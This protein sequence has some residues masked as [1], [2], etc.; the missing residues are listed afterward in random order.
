MDALSP[1]ASTPE[2]GGDSPSS[3]KWG[4]KGLRSPLRKNTVSRKQQQAA[5]AASSPPA[6]A[7]SP[8][9]THDFSTAKDDD[10]ECEHHS[11]RSVPVVSRKMAAIEAATLAAAQADAAAASERPMSQPTPQGPAA[12]AARRRAKAAAAAAASGDESTFGLSENWLLERSSITVGRTIGNSS[13]GSVNEGLLNGTK[14]AVKTIKR[15]PSAT[16]ELETIAKEAELNCQLR[17]PNIV[18]FMGIA[19]APD[20]VCIVTEMMGRGNVHDLLIGK[21]GRQ[22]KLEPALRLQWAIDTAQGMA[23]LHSLSPP[24]IHRDL[25]TTNLLV[26]RGMNVKICDF[27]LSRYQ[28]VDKVMTAVGTVQ[29]AAPEVL[30]HEMY[31]EKVD[32]FSYG[33]VMWQLYTRKAVFDGQ[34]QLEVFQAVVM[35]NMPRVDAECPKKYRE[36]MDACWNLDPDKRPAFKEVIEQLSGLLEGGE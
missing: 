12:V 11:V 29:F 10:Q 35:G 36:V 14:V 31:S 15:D 22:A 28:A 1:A 20:E 3:R 4:K 26:D 8:S 2:S 7:Q 18:L 32:L 17:H 5:L 30:K 33:T 23:Y 21:G 27:G 13:F 19:L 24:M 25:K 34:P 6:A 16:N 9:L